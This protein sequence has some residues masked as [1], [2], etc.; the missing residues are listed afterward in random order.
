MYGQIFSSISK[1]A[2]A[3]IE[4]ITHQK[5]QFQT[6]FKDRKLNVAYMIWRQPWMAAGGETFINTL[7]K[8][9]GLT[10]VFENRSSRYPEIDLNELKDKKPDIILLSSEPY[11]FKD[12]HIREIQQTYKVP[13]ILVDGEYFSWYGSRL[14]PAFDYFAKFQRQLSTFL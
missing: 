8:L 4:Q 9:N 13:V 11:P 6:D 7:L 3:L 12:H 2:T 1:K 10:N 14:I 5:F